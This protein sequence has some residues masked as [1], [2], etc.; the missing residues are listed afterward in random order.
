M[1]IKILW[2][3]LVELAAPVSGHKTRSFWVNWN[4]KKEKVISSDSPVIIYQLT[5][6]NITDNLNVQDTLPFFVV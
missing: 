1:K 4:C 2:D 6:H 3:I 5:R